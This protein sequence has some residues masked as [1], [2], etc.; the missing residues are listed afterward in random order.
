MQIKV[1]SASVYKLMNQQD[2]LNKLKGCVQFEKM[3]Q[4]GL[5]VLGDV[6]HLP[7]PV[8]QTPVF[9]V[10]EIEDN[11]ELG[12]AVLEIQGM[13]FKKGSLTEMEE[14]F[15]KLITSLVK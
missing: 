5:S 15:V 7:N 3:K 14:H 12:R 13:K 2:N 11:S 4:L 10:F 8:N 9:K 6:F 1:R